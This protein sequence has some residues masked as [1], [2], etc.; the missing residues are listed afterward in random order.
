MET[1]PAN[2]TFKMLRKF[3]PRARRLAGERSRVGRE[4]R[5]AGG[6]KC[7]GAFLA[8][9]RGVKPLLQFSEIRCFSQGK[10]CDGVHRATVER[11]VR[12]KSGGAYLAKNYLRNF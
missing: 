3:D 1:Y 4:G 12:S 9:D 5:V 8:L 6:E 7:E 2:V 10:A 11:R